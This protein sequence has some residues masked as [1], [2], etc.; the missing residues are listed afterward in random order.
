MAE[1]NGW[2]LT[3][4]MMTFDDIEICMYA[5][6]EGGNRDGGGGEGRKL[7]ILV[8]HMAAG[9]DDI[10]ARVVEMRAGTA[11]VPCRSVTGER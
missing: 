7:A 10:R 3:I 4:K 6:W 8:P 1:G 11:H 9:V 2:K 5:G